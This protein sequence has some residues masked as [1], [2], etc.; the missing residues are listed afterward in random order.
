MIVVKT[1]YEAIQLSAEAIP[2]CSLPQWLIC[3]LYT[4][5]LRAFPPAIEAQIKTLRPSVRMLRTQL[6][7][8]PKQG[9]FFSEPRGFQNLPG[10]FPNRNSSNCNLKS[11]HSP[12]P[13]TPSAKPSIFHSNLARTEISYSQF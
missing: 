8:Y 5:N 11:P 10:Q 9:P 3:T 6:K 2:I 1:R 7:I 4:L 12:S 13:A